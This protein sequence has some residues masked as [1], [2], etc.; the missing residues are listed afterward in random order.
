MR[1][2][3]MYFFSDVKKG[4]LVSKIV[5]EIAQI[6]I[7]SESQI[8]SEELWCNYIIGKLLGSELPW[9]S[10]ANLIS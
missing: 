1:N 7:K 3:K 10:V 5:C 9:L 6:T 2:K 4:Q 8:N